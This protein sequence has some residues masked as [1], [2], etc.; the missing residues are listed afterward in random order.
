VQAQDGRA[1]WSEAFNEMFAQV[2]GVFGNASVRRHGRWYVCTTAPYSGA[3]VG[4]LGIFA[5]IAAVAG[6]IR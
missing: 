3:T 2:A 1:A 6:P 4:L 5:V